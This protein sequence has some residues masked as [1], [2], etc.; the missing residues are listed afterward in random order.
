M[1]L[2]E[3]FNSS[4]RVY[5]D[6]TK[7]SSHRHYSLADKLVKEIMDYFTQTIKKRN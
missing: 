4:T 6:R 3:L 1:K 5:S 2:K 7:C